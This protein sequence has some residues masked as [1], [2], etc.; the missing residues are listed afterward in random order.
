MSSIPQILKIYILPK[1]LEICYFRYTHI[2]PTAPGFGPKPYIEYTIFSPLA[3]H[4][5]VLLS[6]MRYNNQMDATPTFDPSHDILRYE[7]NPLNA[8]FAPRNVALIG[9]TE[10]AG[11][12]GR[13]IMWNLISNPFG[14]AV[15]PVNPKRNSVLGV[16][17]YPRIADLP[18]PVDLAVV[19]TP[20]P[21]VPG[22]IE[23]CVQAGAKGA[24]IISA[25]F[26]EVGP[27]GADLERQ[28]M[29]H[30]RLAKMRVIGPNCLGVM[31]PISGLNATFA[32]AMARPGNV[33]FISQSGALCTAVLDWSL[34][35]NVGFSAFV[36][37]GSML[38]VGWGDLI[39]YLGDDPNT[40]SILIYMETIGDARAFLSAAR[41]VSNTKPVIVIKPGRTDAAAKAAASHTGSL[42]GS[43]DVLEVAFR[44]AGVLRVNSIAELFYTA[45]VLS[46]QPRPKGSRLTIL[47]NAGGPGVL[48][49][50]ALITNGG[51]LAELSEPTL[52]AFDQLLPTAWSHNN[53]VDLL[54]DA[55][56]E[57]YAKALEIAAADPNSDGLLVILT[58]QAMTSPTATAEQLI[59]YADKLGKPILASWMGGAEV[60]AGIKTLNRVNIP[61]FPYP[62]TAARMFDYMANYALLLSRLYET[63]MISTDE[64]EMPDESLAS[65][66]LKHARD[67]GRTLLT[68]YESKALLSAYHIPTVTTQIAASEDEAVRLAEETGFPVVLKL[69]SETITHKTDVGGVQLDLQDVQA[70]REAFHTIR[71]GA[72]AAAGELSADGRPNFLGV[73]VQPMVSM[74]G[75]ELILGSSID[76]QFGPVLLFG[77]GGQLVEVFKDR[78]LGLPPLNTTLARRMMESTKVYTALKGVRGRSPV[79]LAALE[80]LMVRFS[81]LI[82]CQP[83]IKEIDI[84]P[85][86]ASPERLLALDARVVLHDSKTRE[87]DLPR[88]AIRPYP[89][90]YISHW[91]IK[92][93]S[94]IVIRPIKAEDEP[95]IVKFH[96][97]LS[98][99]SVYLRFRS[100]ALLSQR[101]AHD[102][103]SRICHSDYDREISLEAEKLNA[104]EGELRILGAARMSKLHG[105]NAARFSMLVSDQCQGQGIGKKLLSRLVAV[106]RGE[107]LERLEAIMTPDNQAM[108]HLC[109]IHGFQFQQ[110]E[111]GMIKAELRLF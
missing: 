22:V 48:A 104:A 70:V 36:S 64:T 95:E 3:R 59:P 82:A 30:A 10:T 97:T 45:E 9:A 105:T 18:E 43:D 25:G 72:M 90:Q 31:N 29:E 66:I 92:D 17:T 42:T 6:E 79:D 81:Q 55:S 49:T 47:T 91:K 83:W 8:L 65:Q 5:T 4:P 108:H 44:R 27:T 94:T 38:D 99:R 93:G 69:H 107:K 78:A 111:D 28:I 110:M 41:E 61:T 2:A 73:T 26:K 21:T 24:I 13:T 74:E 88:L 53:P 77:T 62:D 57:R 68:E 102:R 109:E 51:Q 96:Q 100:P 86:L 85:L 84:N 16:K 37:I 11:S 32:A 33:G 7:H 14:G 23:E 1:F 19:V 12:V 40:Q 34:Q 60:E 20:A 50:D 87:A 15:F 56:P 63:P 58:P 39:Y 80:A 89:S 52:Q 75:Y 76:P 54:G 46:K 35:E 101:A 98:D 67:S 71:Q 103:L 106:A